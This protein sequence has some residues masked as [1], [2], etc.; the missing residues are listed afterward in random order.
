MKTP[1]AILSI[2]IFTGIV[3]YILYALGAGDHHLE[4]LWALGTS[5][6]FLTVLLIDVWMFFA[7]AGEEAYRWKI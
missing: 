5:I 1:L 4:P 3:G 7:I 6:I 2:A